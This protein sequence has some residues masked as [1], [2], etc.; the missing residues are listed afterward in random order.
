MPNLDPN[1]LEGFTWA[2]GVK[3]LPIG[4][5]MWEEDDGGKMRMVAV[6]TKGGVRRRLVVGKLDRNYRDAFYPQDES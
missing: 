4:P 6:G 5:I 3:E 2:E 1:L